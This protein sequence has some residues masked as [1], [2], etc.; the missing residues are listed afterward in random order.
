MGN[1]QM[2]AP[3]DKLFEGFTHRL[4]LTHADVIALTKATAYAIFP[5]LLGAAT[6]PA[7]TRIL[8]VAVDIHAAGVKSTETLTLSI[9]DGSSA[10]RF[11]NAV[12]LKSATRYQGGAMPYVYT[13]A[14]TLDMTI[15]TDG[16]DLTNTTALVVD[17]LLNIET[18]AKTRVID[19]PLT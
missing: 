11:V 19:P 18:I 15:G 12:N 7:G 17:I 13:S 5:V 9:G 4:R 2:L 6:F 3:N 8:D 10:T 1:L 14:D 16:T